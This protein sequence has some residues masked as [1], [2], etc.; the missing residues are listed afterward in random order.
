MDKAFLDWYT[1]SLGGIMGLVTCM[2]A[3]L[4]SNMAV[5]GNI[6]QKLD[7]IGIGGF[8]ASYT[9]IPLCIIIT[10]LGS[11]E[12]NIKNENITNVNRILLIITTLIGFLGT[13]IYFII[14]AIFILFKFYSSYICINKNSEKI[15]QKETSNVN[16]GNNYKSEKISHE[17]TKIYVD[18]KIAKNL[19][20]TR[21]EIA[22]DLLI[23]GADK[24]FICELTSLSL[25]ELEAIEYKI[26]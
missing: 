23:K 6:F 19:A 11:I 10:I 18:K 12:S 24:N 25:K 13:K 20:R 22:V 2:W 15:P 17:S 9:L 3:Y 26:K 16:S 14:P 7:E 5:Y 21:I 4:N 8:I 1:Q